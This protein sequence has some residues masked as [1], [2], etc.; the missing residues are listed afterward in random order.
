MSNPFDRLNNPFDDSGEKKRGKQKNRARLNT[1]TRDGEISLFIKHARKELGMTQ[2][3][4]AAKVGI[5]L[6]QL[7]EIE[8][9]DLTKSLQLYLR[10]LILFRKKL[11]IA[12]DPIA[13]KGD[14]S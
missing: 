8:A 10:I 7:R 1:S 2:N 11:V 5:G 14:E 4:F 12:D 3:D 13:A 6:R 9:G